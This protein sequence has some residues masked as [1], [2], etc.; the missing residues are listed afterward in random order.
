MVEFCITKIAIPSPLHPKLWYKPEEKQEAQDRIDQLTRFITK[1]IHMDD[2][3]RR[4][5]THNLPP[6]LTS[7]L[8]R[9]EKPHTQT[10]THMHITFTNMWEFKRWE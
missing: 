10:C 5:I 6:R 8:S 7:V 1:V 9:T 2:P 4:F 3:V